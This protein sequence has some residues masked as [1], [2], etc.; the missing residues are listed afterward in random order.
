M[1]FR[2][3]QKKSYCISI[4]VLRRFSSTG[5]F[6]S[7]LLILYRTTDEKGR[8]IIKNESGTKYAVRIRLMYDAKC[9]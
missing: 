3:S 8:N 7:E 4:G 6:F 9:E 2:Y 1:F 5:V